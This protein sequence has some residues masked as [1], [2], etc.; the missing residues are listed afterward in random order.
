MSQRGI[1][2]RMKGLMEW[3]WTLKPMLLGT[4]WSFH[5]GDW[6]TCSRERAVRVHDEGGAMAVC[7]LRSALVELDTSDPD[8]AADIRGFA[9]RFLFGLPVQ[10]REQYGTYTLRDMM[11]YKATKDLLIGTR[12][13]PAGSPLQDAEVR[14]RLRALLDTGAIIETEDLPPVKETQVRKQKRVNK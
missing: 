11:G 6:L 13:Y 4:Q 8:R 10:A 2:L 12:A 3:I 1:F 9:F 5:V 14:D 7:C